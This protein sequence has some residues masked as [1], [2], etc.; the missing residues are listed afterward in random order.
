MPRGL[1]HIGG[2][3]LALHQM[4]II[5]AMDFFLRRTVTLLQLPIA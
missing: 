2:T 4:L 5:V 3:C 1:L